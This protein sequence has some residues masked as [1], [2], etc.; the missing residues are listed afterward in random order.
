M[1]NFPSVCEQESEKKGLVVESR[2]S[3]YNLQFYGYENV[4]IR[5]Y[6]RSAPCDTSAGE[7]ATRFV[8]EI[9]G[10]VGFAFSHM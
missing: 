5:I 6:H 8:I 7:Y 9:S 2:P 4:P 3:F 10:K 1:V